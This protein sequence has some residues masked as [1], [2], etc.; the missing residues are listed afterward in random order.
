VDGP[1]VAEHEIHQD[2]AHGQSTG[3]A[4]GVAVARVAAVV[5]PAVLL[6]GGGVQLE[7]LCGR[8]ERHRVHHPS[9]VPH[10]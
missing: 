7:L 4:C 3:F 5:Q 2:T 1:T 9:R 8:A 10:S 6:A